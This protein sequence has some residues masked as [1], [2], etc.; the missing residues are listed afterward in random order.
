MKKE[1]L[2]VIAAF[3]FGLLVWIFDSAVDSLLFYEDSFLGLTFFN[4]PKPE[5][6]FRAEV[7]ISFTIFGVIISL[8]FYKQRKTEEALLRI[9]NELEKRVEERTAKLSE[10]NE[11]LNAEIAERVHAENSLRNNQKMLKTVFDGISDPLVLLDGDMR[12]KMINNAASDYYRLSNDSVIFDSKCYQLFLDSAAPCKGC[13][14]PDALS[15]SENKQFERKGF[16]DPERIESVNLYP[17]KNEDTNVW[18]ILIRISDITE[19]RLLDKRIIQ[20]EKMATLGVLIASVAHEINNPISFIS[21]NIPILKDYIKELMAIVDGYALKEPDFELFNM[22]YEEFHKDIFKLLDNLNH[23]SARIKAFVSN[24]KGFSQVKDK[25]EK[26]WMDLNSTIERVLN[27]SQV[28]QLKSIKFFE[29][30]IPGSLPKIW[31]DPH[32]LEQILLNLL[33]NA[34]QAVSNKKDSRV[35]F[36]VKIRNSWLDHLIFEIVDNGIGMDEKTLEKIFDPFFTSKS[37]PEGTGLGLYVC[38]DLVNRLEGHIEVESEPGKGSTF[39]VILPD[40]ERR[41]KKR[42]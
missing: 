11:I 13:E 24:L 21:F 16:M 38:Q 33:I 20:Q 7:L 9:Q 42:S 17:V 31:S 26:K 22:S 27:I 6:F 4:I 41:N 18:D 5:L 19:Q 3:I 36:N 35:V 30:N 32:A 37:L 12:V 40:K 8:L 29:A 25:I 10:A 15:S 1:I 2:I 28:L 39:R 14:I 34:A 23:G